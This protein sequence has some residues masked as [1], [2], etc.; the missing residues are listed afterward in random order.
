[1]NLSGET[2]TIDTTRAVFHALMTAAEKARRI[3]RLSEESDIAPHDAASRINAL[4]STLNLALAEIHD[5][6]PPVPASL[7]ES[8]AI[9]TT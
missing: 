7:T 3:M 1:M 4:L 2:I 9:R 6:A 8:L 5:P